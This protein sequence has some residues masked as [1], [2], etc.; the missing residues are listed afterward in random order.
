MEKIKHLFAWPKYF[1]WTARDHICFSFLLK[2]S[3][4]PTM[5]TDT[6]YCTVVFALLCD[7]NRIGTGHGTLRSP[8]KHCLN[9]ATGLYKIQHPFEE[10]DSC[11]ASLWG[12]GWI[13]WYRFIIKSAISWLFG[14][15]SICYLLSLVKKVPGESSR[16]LLHLMWPLYGWKE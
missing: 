8:G 10:A 12:I 13:R 14:D 9:L 3:V 1:N 16:D 7:S 15:V 2:W 5:G 11:Q 4:K 6:T